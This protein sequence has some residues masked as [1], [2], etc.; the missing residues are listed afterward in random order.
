MDNLRREVLIHRDL[1]HPNII[2]LFNFFE[3]GK[4]IYL[5]LEYLPKG[6]LYD[7]MRPRHLEDVQ[8]AKIFRDVMSAVH[9]LHQRKIFHRDIKPENVLLDGQGN[10]KLCDFGF[11]AIFGNGENRKTLCGTKEYLAPEVICSDAQ[12]DKVDIWCMGVLLYELV[13]KKPPYA[14]KNIMTLYN[15]IKMRRI[16]FKPNIH[17]DFRRIIEMCLQ[18]EPSARPTAQFIVDSFHWLTDRQTTSRPGA[19]NG[20]LEES[21]GRPRQPEK[22]SKVNINIG[23]VNI[24][25]VNPQSGGQTQS[26]QNIPLQPRILPATPSPYVN[27]YTGLPQSES[28]RVVGVPMDYRETK[29]QKISV[30]TKPDSKDS[31]TI[32]QPPSFNRPSSESMETYQTVKF[33]EHGV[34]HHAHTNMVNPQSQYHQPF[35]KGTSAEDEARRANSLMENLRPREVQHHRTV[36][37]PQINPQEGVN[38]PRVV[39]QSQKNV[40]VRSSPVKSPADQQ[41]YPHIETSINRNAGPPSQHSFSPAPRQATKHFTF[42]NTPEPT[43]T[44]LVNQPTPPSRFVDNFTAERKPSYPTEDPSLSR[45]APP[46][47]SSH[48]SFTNDVQWVDSARA[49]KGAT[50]FHKVNSLNTPSMHVVNIYRREPNEPQVQPP[51]I[52]KNAPT[53][54]LYN[55]P[56]ERPAVQT[57]QRIPSGANYQGTYTPVSQKTSPAL[58]V[59]YLKPQ[60][61]SITRS[62]PETTFTQQGTGGNSSVDRRIPSSSSVPRRI[63]SIQQ[64]PSGAVYGQEFV[65]QPMTI[66]KVVHQTPQPQRTREVRST[67]A[68]ISEM[69]PV[70]YVN[71]Y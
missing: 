15:E 34:F 13:H 35:L 20:R 32:G 67:S 22:P 6:N 3:V 7:Y 55:R 49:N 12:D 69:R 33:I 58:P 40:V 23:S 54:D 59:T 2:R 42:V 21:R 27:V 61:Y 37:H 28:E 50:G 24:N 26:L 38:Q 36:Q 56:P 19:D 63:Q 43:A 30:T 1:H 51:N 62:P 18:L 9:F 64:M 31:R 44:R 65:S 10:F 45:T 17:P 11:S 47:T 4:Q 46:A 25:I 41:T 52:Y 5:L 14:C 39:V 8:V 66:T 48:G 71:Y 70:R 68:Q 53:N 29:T 60:T 16:Q 57:Y